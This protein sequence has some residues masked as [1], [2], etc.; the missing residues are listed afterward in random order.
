MIESFADK[1]TE[2]IFSGEHVKKLDA[3]LQTKVLRRLRYLDA[4]EQ[5][6]DLRIPPSNRLEKKEGDLQDFYAIWVNTQW[7]IIF[8]WK[9]N[10]AHDVQ[11]IDYH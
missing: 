5:L 1:R 7:R 11:L 3:N 9:D 6:D 4:A 2:Q 8:R 10:G